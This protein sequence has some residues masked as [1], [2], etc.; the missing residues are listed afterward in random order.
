MI[1]KLSEFFDKIKEFMDSFPSISDIY[2]K[3][4]FGIPSFNYKGKPI[5]P[6]LFSPRRW[7]IFLERLSVGLIVS[8]LAIILWVFPV[9]LFVA[10]FYSFTHSDKVEEFVIYDGAEGLTTANALRDGLIY[11]EDSLVTNFFGVRNWIDNAENEQIGMIEMYRISAY[12]LENHLGRNRGSGGANEC[13]K[14]ARADINADYT[15]PLFTSYNTRLESAI[16]NIDCYTKQLLEDQSKSMNDKRA[17]FIVNSD[18]LAEALDKIKQQ[19]DNPI[20]AS[21]NMSFFEQDDVFYQIRGNL[22]AMYIFLKGIDH[23][24]RDKMIDKTL[25]EQ[26]FTPVLILLE[27]AI[28]YNP[29]VIL[30]AFGHVDKLTAISLDIVKKMGELRDKLKKGWWKSPLFK[31]DFI[32]FK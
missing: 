25:Y 27:E 30:N 1:G 4:R 2:Q 5:I 13:L 31:S 26:N 14:S 12:M 21:K 24:F 20:E 23:D 15:I 10:P 16:R 11:L 7:L 3:F 22:I 28:A 9:S 17:V 29:I 19:L 18:N 6:F 8:L 32:G